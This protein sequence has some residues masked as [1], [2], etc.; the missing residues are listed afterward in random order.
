L[1]SLL[2]FVG[3]Y[4]LLVLG[5][6]ALIVVIMARVPFP[7][8]FFVVVPPIIFLL[9]LIKGFFAKREPETS[10]QLEIFPEEH[11]RLLDFLSRLCDD[12]GA[13][14]PHRIVVSPEINAAVFYEESLL[15]L[16]VPPPKNLLIG[17]GLVNVLTLSEFKAVMAHELGHFSQRGMLLRRYL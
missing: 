4:L 15:G 7:F 14:V 17:L 1:V 13:P 6:A 2:A 3:L 12:T 5:T 16:I 10:F 8:N 11:P 9:F